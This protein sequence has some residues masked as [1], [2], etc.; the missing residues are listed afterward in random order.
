MQVST[1]KTVQATFHLLE[2]SN[3]DREALRAI[4]SLII[5]QAET[6]DRVIEFIEDHKN[7]ATAEQILQFNNELIKVVKDAAQNLRDN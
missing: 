6:T 1:L 7:G 4:K 5:T 3:I 2:L